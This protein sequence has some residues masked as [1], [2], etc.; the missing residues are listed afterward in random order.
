VNASILSF[1]L[2]LEAN[3]QFLHF[4]SPSQQNQ[5]LSWKTGKVAATNTIN[6]ENTKISDFNY[7]VSSNIPCMKHPNSSPAGICSS[8]LKDKLL[9]L[10]CSDQFFSED[11]ERNSSNIIHPPTNRINLLKTIKSWNFLHEFRQH[12]FQLHL[13]RK[14]SIRKGETPNF[15]ELTIWI[16]CYTFP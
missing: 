3:P 4:Q 8:C 7:F 12:N 2:L 15:T 9:N 14:S 6:G 11:T 10:N 1:F 5:E 13:N 16:I